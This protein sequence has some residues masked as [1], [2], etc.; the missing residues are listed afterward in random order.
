MP[1]ALP[2]RLRQKSNQERYRE[3]KEADGHQYQHDPVPLWPQFRTAHR[4]SGLRLRRG[5]PP[6]VA[7]PLV[8]DVIAA[9]DDAVGGQDRLSAD[10]AYRVLG[11]DFVRATAL[12]LS[13]C[14]RPRI[15]Q[16]AAGRN[17]H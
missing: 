12:G 16:N 5:P 6:P 11:T 13:H 10:S 8:D 7:A 4:A 3:N 2:G 17:R 1:G 9:P 15:I 14:E